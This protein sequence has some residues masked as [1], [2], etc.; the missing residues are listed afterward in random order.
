MAQLSGQR[1]HLGC[2]ASLTMPAP[3]G[4]NRIEFDDAA[5]EGFIAA[6]RE[7][8]LHR[9][10]NVLH[11]Q[12]TLIWNEVAK[13]VGVPGR[14]RSLVPRS[15][16]ADRFDA[17]D[18]S[19][20]K[21]VESHLDWC[22]GADVFAADTRSRALAPRTLK[23]RRNQIHA[24]VTALVESGVKP[25]DIRSLADLI[26]PT[27]SSVFYAGGSKSR[28]VARMPSI[29]ISPK[30]SSK[31]VVSGSSWSPAELTNSNRLTSK[32]P[33]PKPGLTSKNKAALRQFDDPAVLQRLAGLP[34]RLW[35]EVKREEKPNFRTLAKAQAA[36]GI[37]MLTY[38]PVRPGNL[39]EL[40]FDVH[41]FIRK[42]P[43]AISSLE[44]SA[45]EVKN[46]NEMAFDIPPRV[47]QDCRSNI[48]IASR[49]K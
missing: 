38:M 44:L 27:T 35:A 36:L 22:G 13:T 5:I 43:H 9:K 34:K 21:D 10:P 37:A 26:S 11:R 41:L 3:T 42:E 49:R 18:A 48:A 8:S 12:V 15:D 47:R 28:V 1:A 30:R 23:L 39:S 33:M 7:G 45:G 29:A 46:D 4:S 25:S 20:Q 6:V 24:V 19:L 40:T 2:R 16:Q 17:V 31:S 32:V 14:S